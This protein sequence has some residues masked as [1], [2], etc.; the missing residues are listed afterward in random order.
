MRVFGVSVA[1]GILT[2]ALMRR[3]WRQAA[4]FCAVLL[5]FGGELV[6]RWFHTPPVFVR[7]SGAAPPGPGFARAWVYY[8]SYVGFWK[9]S[10]PNSHIL[11]VMLKNNALVTFLSPSDFFLVPLLKFN[12]LVSSGL[13]L[14]VTFA[15]LAGIVRQSKNDGWKAIHFAF[16]FYTAV[17]LIWNY[18]SADRFFFLF[19]P[20]FAGALW[21]ETRHFLTTL[22]DTASQSRSAAEKAIAVILAL[23][24]LALLIGVIL[25]FAGGSRK[26]MAQ[27]VLERSHLAGEKREA[28]DWLSCCTSP[29]DRVVA[30][31]DATLYL[32]SGRQSMRPVVFPTSGQFDGQYMR[33]SF[34]QMTDVAHAIGARYWLVSDDDFG[35]EWDNPSVSGLAMELE[36]TRTAPVAF[37]S[38]GGH[39]RI[40]KF[41]CDDPRNAAPCP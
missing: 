11:W 27:V 10:V 20:L 2:A 8:T 21:V 32:Y 19:L 29:D 34:D 7:A 1:A 31:E 12:S 13:V 15:I 14:L 4:I 22:Y 33:E 30:Y 23:G 26:M 39:I 25:N 37:Q 24:V 3:S 6:S 16:P 18:P 28:Y 17:A 5:P 36:L 41:G 40:Y 9:L 35:L 38:Q